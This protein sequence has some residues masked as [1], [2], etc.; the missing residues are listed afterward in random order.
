MKAMILDQQV[1]VYS[2]MD[3]NAVSIAT[4]HAGNE[5]EFSSAKRKAGKVWVPITMSMGQQAYI[6]GE[7]KIKV[8]QLGSLLQNDVAVHNEPSTDSLIKEKLMR[9]T[10][11]YILNVIKSAGEEWVKVRN[12]VGNEGY[13]DGK[14][15][16]RVIP[17]QTK[18]SAMRNITSGLLWLGAGLIILFSNNTPASGSSYMVFGYAAMFLGGVRLIMGVVNW[19]KAPS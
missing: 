19:L 5:I 13:I 12:M 6:P 4:L 7:T 8:I 18:A 10:K 17:Q 15:R 2:S 3:A 16:I 1:K 11:V 9:G 14:T